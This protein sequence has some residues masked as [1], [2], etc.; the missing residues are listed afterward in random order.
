MNISECLDHQISDKGINF[1]H[2]VEVEGSDK[3]IWSYPLWFV[4]RQFK[5]L[6]GNI[7]YIIWEEWMQKGFFEM[8]GNPPGW[9]DCDSDGYDPE[10][11]EGDQDTKWFYWL[12]TRE[13]LE[14]DLVDFMSFIVKKGF[15][16]S[17]AQETIC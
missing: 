13:I 8:P 11:F 14:G 3:E 15:G 7:Q 6:P 1:S 2:I 4:Y 16:N 12:D 9:D 17:E 10:S 5:Q